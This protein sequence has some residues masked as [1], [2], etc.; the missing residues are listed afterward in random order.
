MPKTLRSL[1]P[2]S[3]ASGGLVLSALVLSAQVLVAL[4]L[5]A[6]AHTAPALANCG[7]GET[8]IFHCAMKSGG[9]Q[10]S[11]CLEGDTA[12]YAYGRKGAEPELALSAPRDK[13]DLRLWNGVG[14][15]I[16]ES[17]GFRNGA[18]RY[19]AS[20]AL[21]RLDPSCETECKIT[22]GL[23][24]YKDKRELADLACWPETLIQ[25]IWQLAP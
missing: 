15:H 7:P 1:L 11:I 13:V 18:Y 14:R 24:V 5:S 6:I 20:Y 22:S 9:K 17:V 2:S 3:I 4:V 25:N 19:V 8:V 16:E 10:V 12:T 21:D 23:K